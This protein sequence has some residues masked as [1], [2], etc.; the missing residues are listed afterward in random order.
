MTVNTATIGYPRIGRN[1]EW[2]KAIEA[3]WKQETTEAELHNQLHELYV[4]QLRIQ[5]DKGIDFVSVGDFS[6]YDHM[7]DTAVMFNIIP[8]RFKKQNLSALDTYYAMARGNKEAEACEMTKWFNTNYHY[9]VPEFT[10][11][12]PAL[13]ENRPL[14]YWQ[15]AKD[16]LALNG[17]PLLIGPATFILLG[18]GFKQEEVSSLF[19][20]LTPL[21]IQVIKELHEAGAE[22]IQIDEPIFVTNKAEGYWKEVEAFYQRISEE[23]PGANLIIQTYFEA[24]DNYQF[25]VNLPVNAFGLDFVHDERKNSEAIKAHGFPK[26]KKLF[27]GVIDG[28]NVWKSNLIEKAALVSELQKLVGKEEVIVQPSS[29]LLH[30]PVTVE[31][32]QELAADIRAGLSFAEEK[33]TELE[34]LKDLLKG[35]SEAVKAHQQ[36]IEAFSKVANRVHTKTRAELE[37]ID[38]Q[39]LSRASVAERQRLQKE[40]FD[41]PLLPTTTI[42][43]LPQTAEVRS[44]RLKWKQGQLTNEQ[45]E[46][47]I[48]EETKRWIEVQEEI[49]IDVLVHGEFE[50]TD[51][52]EFFGERLGGMLTT[53][54]GWVQSYGSRCV[55][56]PVVYGDVY[57]VEPM[58]VKEIVYAQSLTE[59]VVKGMLT[60]PITILNWSF[61]R[62][63]ISKYESMNQIALAIR[64]EVKALEEAGVH[65]I[66][67]DEP[68]LREG[69]PIRAEKQDA[70]LNATVE[71]FRLA[72]TGVEDTTQIHTHM[73]YSKFDDMIDTISA[74]DADVISIEASRSHGNIIS[75]FEQYSYDKEI[76]LGIY[77]IHSP[78]IPSFEEMT[79]NLD[80]ALRVLNPAQFWVNPDCGLK[81]R[82]EKQ[83]IDALTQMVN[84]TKKYRE[85]LAAVAQ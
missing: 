85:K 60:G 78:R 22:W 70:Y 82:N 79:N 5:K 11:V 4:N 20:Q 16:E 27:A 1:R 21:Y 57:L 75:S 13:N 35:D 19:A 37:Q 12:T 52:V 69:L 34:L 14:A 81:T 63:D 48:K 31:T 84:V 55:R 65:M 66:Q 8:A 25:V 36:E 17:K 67:V 68:A 44:K 74:L 42:G 83:V 18:K 71:A 45:Y 56:P 72:T 54:N 76:G 29:T 43:S 9:I 24:L 23:V 62:T 28:R 15:K 33:L 53:K 7:L 61:P 39:A 10:D 41:L 58:T 30:V 49:G 59:K 3:Y 2:K 6:Y 51:M 77:D 26:G 46:A 38:D 80:R 64:K 32:E 50:R 47:F 73:C 40:K